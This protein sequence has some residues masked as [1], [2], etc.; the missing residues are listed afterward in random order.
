VSACRRSGYPLA[1][2]F[3]SL[4]LPVMLLQSGGKLQVTDLKVGSGPAAQN[5]DVLVMDY[6]GTLLSGKEFD[7]SKKPGRTPFQ[8]TIGAGMVIKGWDQGILGMKVGGRRHLIIPPSLGYGDQAM[9]TDIPSN[10]TLVF[11]VELKKILRVKILTTKVGH[12]T[13]VKL[14]QSVQVHYLGKFTD[15]KKFDS[16][17]DRNE[18]LTVTL[19]RQGLIPGFTQGILGMK[20]GEKRTVTIPPELGYGARQAGPIPPNSTLVF[21]LELVKVLP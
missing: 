6:T 4:I 20:T 19:G 3:S 14:G 7:S 9:G 12:G 10:S 16:S 2:Q 13:P 5:G 1:M 18:P 17:Y 21:E 11:D 8:F 15:G